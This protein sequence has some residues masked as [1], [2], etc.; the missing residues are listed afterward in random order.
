MGRSKSDIFKSKFKKENIMN[1]YK[2]FMRSIIKSKQENILRNKNL[3][4][5]SFYFNKLFTT[6]RELFHEGKKTILEKKAKK[7]TNKSNEIIAIY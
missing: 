3:V 7:N 6:D 1:K 4:G 2:K 5:I